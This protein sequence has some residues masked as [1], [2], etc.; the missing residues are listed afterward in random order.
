MGNRVQIIFTDDGCPITGDPMVY[1]H[2]GGSD[3]L[4]LLQE[5]WTG[6]DEC[7]DAARF[8]G[9]YCAE[10]PGQLGI[11]ISGALVADASIT[12][13][14]RDRLL[15]NSHGD[16]GIIVVNCSNREYHC[17]CGDLEE[18]NPFGF[19]EPVKVKVAS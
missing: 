15:Q 5:Y 2:W 6:K 19:I 8:V 18:T 17:Y 13:D 3:A 11:G 14:W 10:N 12:L 9:Q 16:A 7:Y 4:R 1:L